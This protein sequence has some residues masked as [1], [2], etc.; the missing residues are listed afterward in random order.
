MLFS[1]EYFVLER[2]Q[3]PSFNSVETFYSYEEDDLFYG[4]EY[5]D[6]E[7]EDESGGMWVIPK[8]LDF[9]RGPTSF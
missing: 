6:Y 9:Y 3:A 4:S 1:S 2:M 5:L 7:L 8:I